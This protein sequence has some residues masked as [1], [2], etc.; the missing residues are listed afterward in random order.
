MVR[1]RMILTSLQKATNSNSIKSAQR[2]QQDE[3][4]RTGANNMFFGIG[5]GVV[6]LLIGNQFYWNS[7]QSES[8]QQIQ[9]KQEQNRQR[10]IQEGQLLLQKYQEQAIKKIE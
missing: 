4:Y 5:L 3:K 9:R 8:E 2:N 6:F 7:F 1:P 10:G